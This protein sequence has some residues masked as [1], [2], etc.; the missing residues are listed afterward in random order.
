[1]NVVWQTEARHLEEGE[2]QELRVGSKAACPGSEPL[3][4]A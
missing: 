2:G 1:M 3:P 4:A